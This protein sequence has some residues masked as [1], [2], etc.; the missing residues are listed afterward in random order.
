MILPELERLLGPGGVIAGDDIEPRYLE[1]ETAGT[2]GKPLAL[3]RPASTEQVASVLFA[4]HAAGQPIVMQGGRTGMTRA[5]LPRDGELIL[6]LERMNTIEMV[7]PEA[8][9]MVVGAGVPLE[10]AQNAAEDAGWRL[11][12]DIGARG[13]CTIG[14]MIATNAG[15]HQVFRYGMMRDQVLGVEAVLADGM[16]VSSMQPMLKNN[17]GYDLKHLLVGSE[18]TLG[19]VTKA[20]LRLRPK[21]AGF[22]TALCALRSYDA[23]TE[24]LALLQKRCSGRLGAFEVMWRDFFER[25]TSSGSLRDPFDVAHPFYVLVESEGFEDGLL[26]AVLTLAMEREIVDDALL[27]Q[28]GMDRERFWT[29]RDAIGEMTRT[30][31]FVEPFDVGAPVGKLGLLAECIGD[32][33]QRELPETRTVFFGHIADGNLH[34]ALELTEESQRATAEVIVYDAVRDVGGTVS[35]EHGIG[36]LKRPWLGHTR[37]DEEIEVMRRLRKAFDPKGILNPDRIF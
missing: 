21:P 18:G 7:D 27:A 3:V 33:L 35:A 20:M 15:G 8:G 23:V 12:V 22:E 11:A 1:D 6:S 13:S 29:Y 9:T 24:L 19:V 5:T 32:R 14:G 34:L 4:C 26:P 36:M 16:V 10:A 30:M 2:C 25:A 17:T 37:S 28:S 31:A